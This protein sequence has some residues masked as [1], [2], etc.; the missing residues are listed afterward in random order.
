MLLVLSGGE[1]RSRLM[2]SFLSSCLVGVQAMAHPGDAPLGQ[3][4]KAAVSSSLV[5]LAQAATGE[6]N[7]PPAIPN[8]ARVS[9]KMIPEKTVDIGTKVMFRV[10]AKKPGY[11][12]LLDIDAT[13]RMSQIF[14]SPEMIVASEEAAMNFIRP[15][16]ELSIPNA[17]AKKTGF[18]YVVT[19][20]AGQAAII[21]IL[22]E[23]RVQILDLPDTGQKSRPNADIIS[24][25]EKWTNALRIPDPATGKLRPSNWS[26]DISSYSIK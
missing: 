4:S 19:P 6:N 17:A 3:T 25:L 2:I 8:A 15:G 11:V 24:D 16:E 20:P 26:F 14:P 21:A 10:T 12:L 23:R 1:M 22:S 5:T 13:G 18:E 9:L 7:L